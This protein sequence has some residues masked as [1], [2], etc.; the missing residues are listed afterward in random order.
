MLKVVDEREYVIKVPGWILRLLKK[1][2][3]LKINSPFCETQDT[4]RGGGGGGAL[5]DKKR[6]QTSSQEQ[7][8]RILNSAESKRF[9]LAPN[10]Q[11]MDIFHPRNLRGLVKP[12]RNNELFC[13]R[14][15]TVGFCYSDCKYKN[16]YNEQSQNEKKEG[17]N[18][19]RKRGQTSRVTKIGGKQTLLKGKMTHLLTQIREKQM[20]ELDSPSLKGKGHT[21][22]DRK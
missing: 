8:K 12:T 9:K 16:G 6:C 22:Y 5:G 2:E 4:N 21:E 3:A 15:H 1:E 11:F 18:S 10:E 13:L 7:S 14:Y 17:E 19:Y 20:S